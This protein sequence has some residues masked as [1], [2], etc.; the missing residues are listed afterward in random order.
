MIGP[1]NVYSYCGMTRFTFVGVPLGPQVS[2]SI[3]A[4]VATFPTR[5]GCASF[6]EMYPRQLS[7]FSVSRNEPEKMLPP[8]FVTTF[9]TPPLKWPNSAD[10]PSVATGVSCTASS[11]YGFVAWPRMFSLTFTPL[12]RNADSNDM[13]PEIEYA[14]FGPDA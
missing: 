5:N 10:T 2:Q 4:P 6:P 11:M 12:M 8:D 13:A 7:L 1:P 9:T 14:P 3:S